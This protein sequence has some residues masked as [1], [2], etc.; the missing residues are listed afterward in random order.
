MNYILLDFGTFRAYQENENGWVTRYVSESGE[1]L[2]IMPPIG[3]GG[4]VVDAE[5]PRLSWML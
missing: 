5:P 3:N 1:E 4:V 2:F